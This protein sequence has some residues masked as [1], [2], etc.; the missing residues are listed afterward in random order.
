M[1]SPD[2]VL[3]VAAFVVFASVV[4]GYELA[5]RI[6]ALYRHSIHAAV[7]R[8]RHGWFQ[9]M[10][11]RESRIVDAQLL[12]WLSNGN[13]FFASTSAIAIGGLAALLG[14]GERA[15]EL[16]GS[17]PYAA[18]TSPLLWEVKVLL[19]MAIIVFAFF[20]FAWAF[21]LSHYTVIMVGATPAHDSQ[22]TAERARHAAAAANVLGIVG[23]HANSGLRA[24]HYAIAGL[25][26]F[27][28]PVALM[29]VT[30]V[31]LAVI[32]RRDHFSRAR[33]FLRE[34]GPGP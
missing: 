24:F 14:A 17:L 11:G 33:A 10:A 8:H 12:G 20:K 15:R 32:V 21:R 26:W 4:V 23:E 5:T 16:V 13:A 9:V 6:P 34:A 7:Q 22:D 28:H 1:T 31:V 18:A 29:V 19:L 3:D 27:Y 2:Y 25:A 30:G